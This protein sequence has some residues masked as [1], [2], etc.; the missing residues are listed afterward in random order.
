MRIEQI[1]SQHR[2]DFA[3][4]LVC[5]H[6]GSKHKIMTGYDDAY[7]HGHVIPAITCKTCGKNRSGEIPENK[8]DNGTVTVTHA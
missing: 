3:A 4:I 1:T 7:Y 6:C 2:N 5:E 8:N